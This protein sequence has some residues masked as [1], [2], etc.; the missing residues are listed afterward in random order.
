MRL[1]IYGGSFD[2]VHFG[3]LLLAECCREQCRLDQVWF[4]PAAVPPHKQRGAVASA[5]ARVD[6]LKLATGG[7]E[8]FA[9]STIE[10]ERGGVSYT[11]DTLESVRG[12]QPEAELFF[13]MGG[14]SLAEFGT[15]REPGRICKLAPPIVVRRAGAAE[16]DYAVLAPLVPAD[17]LE[18]IRRLRVEMP[19]ID[20]SASDLRRRV[21]AGLS[22]RYRTPR[23]VEKYIEANGLYR[24]PATSP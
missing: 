18:A 2:P 16:P 12:Q 8:A 3:H 4:V 6:M 14:D 10:T 22:I 7:H 5:A 15:W 23:S 20:L 1:G 11:V 9:V 21:A 17:R 13:L 19:V 24:A